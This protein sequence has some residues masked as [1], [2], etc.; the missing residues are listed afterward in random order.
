MNEELLREWQVRLGLTDWR[1]WLQDGVDADEMELDGCTG[2]CT[3]QEANKTAIVQLLNP[4]EYGERLFPYD[5]EKTIV[6]EL[7]HIKFSLV[8][9]VS[10]LH[11]RVLHQLIEEFARL[12]VRL[13]RKEDAE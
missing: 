5:A 2:S 10:D 9:G 3:I 12:L 13:K 7:L 8:D 11:E 1:I 4:E 6:H